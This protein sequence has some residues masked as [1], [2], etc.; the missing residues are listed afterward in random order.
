MAMH[1]SRR[2]ER[3]HP[4]SIILIFLLTTLLGCQT[5]RP[6]QTYFPEVGEQAL[7][8]RSLDLR[9]TL[10]VL[11]IALQPGYESL[12]DLASFRIE[13]GAEITSAYL[14]NGEAGTSDVQAEYPHYLAERRR[15]EAARAM[16]VL[17]GEVYF[18]N[19]PDLA[20]ARD[21]AT[22]REQW[23]SDTLQARLARMILQ[24]KPEIILIPRDWAAPGPSR[25]W[26][27]MCADVLAAVKSCAATAAPT[28]T[29]HSIVDWQVQRVLVDAWQG[30]RMTVETAKRSILWKKSYQEIGDEAAGAYASLSSQRRLLMKGVPSSYRLVYPLATTVSSVDGGLPLPV[31]PRLRRTEEEVLQMT[32]YT[33]EGKTGGILKRIV[34]LMDSLDI[35]IAVRHTMPAR[36]R[37]MLLRWKKELEDLRCTALGV[38]VDY[39]ISDTL[40]ADRQ[41]T[42]LEVSEVKGVTKDGKSEIF[43]APPES[44][45]GIN[46]DVEQ[47][48]PLEY[49]AEYRLLSPADLAY[50]YP[51]GQYQIELPNIGKPF[52]FYIIHRASLRE[53]CFFKRLSFNVV[54]APKLIFENLTPVVRVTSGERVVFKLTNVSRDGVA[55]TL[56][57]HEPFAFAFGHPL[58]LS[59]KGASAVDTLFMAWDEKLQEG[60]HLLPVRFGGIPVGQFL[61]RKFQA[62]VVPAKRVGLITGI[63]NSPVAETLRRLHADY[64]L[65]DVK[66]LATDIQK[67]S[68]LIIDQRALT[69]QPRIAQSKESLR[70]FVD[71]GGHL[72]VLAQDASS[73]NATPLW[74]GMQL[75]STLEV[76]AT[77]PVDVESSHPLM[78]TPNL[79]TSSDWD[80]W[81]FQRGYNIVSGPAL[82]SALP[83]VKT[84]HYPLIVSSQDGKGRKTYVD[85]ALHP[86][87]LNIH[88]GSFRLLANLISY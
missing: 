8:Q 28:L 54:Y 10:S 34:S 84:G 72:I 3:F 64:S 22:V 26:E 75:T 21:S 55:D 73:W 13:R 59:T 24:F 81:L 86:Q 48:L 25:R 78:T 88:A 20:A 45:W 11:S 83:A 33:L 29:N 85:L 67:L 56:K 35:L 12:A 6:P 53:L 43:F 4:V 40:L 36:D 50:S 79:I 61:A 42:F 57:I 37:K 16:S 38:E 19:L 52:Y 80:D 70:Q 63:S 87:L 27:M 18:L 82:D 17:N 74:D 32:A 68:V 58:R 71:G 39:T 77:T 66:S 60:S 49:N 65:V 47:K 46:E 76:D 1:L 5:K 2:C 69:L 23:P 62:D 41:L 14:T 7:Y 15:N 30:G 44:G 9:S 51:P 31:S